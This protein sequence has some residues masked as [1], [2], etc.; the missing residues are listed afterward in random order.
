MILNPRLNGLSIFLGAL[1]FLLLRSPTSPRIYLHEQK[2]KREKERFFAS[3]LDED[4]VDIFP[5]F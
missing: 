3:N 2:K 5:V 4:T 1:L